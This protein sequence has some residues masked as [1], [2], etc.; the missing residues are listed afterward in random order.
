MV[1]NFK[2]KEK[3]K[4]NKLFILVDFVDQ[5]R[6]SVE[7]R[8]IDLIGV[9]ALNYK[10]HLNDLKVEIE[11][12]ISIKKLLDKQDPRF[13][14]LTDIFDRS[15]FDENELKFIDNIPV[16]YDLMETYLS[17]ID[18]IDVV[19]YDSQGNLYSATPEID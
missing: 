6:D 7:V 11:F 18:S 12:L 4:A 17:F 2:L 14:N 16:C 1:L 13:S 3:T 9:N 19:Y 10:Y 15:K 5:Y 8:L